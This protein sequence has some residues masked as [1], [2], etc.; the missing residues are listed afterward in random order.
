MMNPLAATSTHYRS[1][2]VNYFAFDISLLADPSMIGRLVLQVVLLMCSGFFS[3]S[4][5]ALFSLSQMDLQKLRRQRH[6]NSDTL[7]ALLD[8][9]R[10]LITSILCGNEMVNI[11]SGHRGQRAFHFAD[12]RRT[13]SR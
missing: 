12:Y 7:H 6:R 3:G 8:Q 11:F 10:R 1:G 2:F 5:T 13:R 4:E 9:P